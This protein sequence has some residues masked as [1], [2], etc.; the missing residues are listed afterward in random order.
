M[1]KYLGWI[2]F[3]VGCLG[4]IA[5]LKNQDPMML[6]LGTL[7]WVGSNFF[8]GMITRIRLNEHTKHRKNE[9]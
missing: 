2:F 3:F 8:E 4:I 5:G 7:L 9:K 1:I 6:S